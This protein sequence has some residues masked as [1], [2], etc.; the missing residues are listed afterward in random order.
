MADYQ[1]ITAQ[2]VII[3]DT[4]QTRSEVEADY[5]E[6]FGSDFVVDPETPQGVMITADIERTDNTKRAM[7][8]VANQINPDLATG[9][10]LDSLFSLFGTARR[11]KT[12]STIAGVQLT[13]VS[14]TIIPEGSEVKTTA[15]DEFRSSIQVTI[16]ASGFAVVDFIAVEYGPIECAAHDLAAITSTGVLGW[17]GVDN[18]NAAVVGRNE[19]TQVQ[20][21]NRRRQVLANR[22]KSTNEAIIS[23]LYEIEELQSLSYLENMESNPQTIDGIYL[24]A[25]SIWVCANGGTGTDIAA[26]MKRYKTIG[27]GFNGSESATI[28]DEASGQPYVINFDRPTQVPLYIKVKVRNAVGLVTDTVR[29]AV[30]AM[31][32]GEIEGEDGFVVGRDV[33]PFE[34]SA[35]INF[36]DA[37]LYVV[38]VELSTDSGST[39]S[40]NTLAIDI[41]KIAYL[42]SKN[43]VFVEVV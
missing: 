11:G 28:I 34:I 18:P 41:N 32:Q 33:S 7:A 38:N 31:S 14:G 26:V 17:T 1:F 2:G 22:G 36:F 43:H 13:G 27:A 37:A 40:N 12:R 20:A 35:A 29:E 8:E 39:W 15:G 9:V 23:S 25:N 16:D 30:W 21:K 10:F 19:E 5:I 6:A 24:K 42:A 3:P 4:S